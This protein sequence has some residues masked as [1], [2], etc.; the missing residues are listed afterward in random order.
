MVIRCF[1]RSGQKKFQMGMR[2]GF[3]T[4]MCTASY[5]EKVQPHI[6]PQGIVC[7]YGV[8]Q[9]SSSTVQYQLHQFHC[10]AAQNPEHDK[11]YHSHDVCRSRVIHHSSSC[12]S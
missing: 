5:T 11:R 10:R 6:L 8:D 12:L 4:Y 2:K 1:L 7:Y 9:Q 3:P